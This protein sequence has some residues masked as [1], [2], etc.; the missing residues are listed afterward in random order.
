MTKREHAMALKWMVSGGVVVKI[1][2]RVL[3]GVTDGAMGALV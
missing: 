1:G 2:N 3:V